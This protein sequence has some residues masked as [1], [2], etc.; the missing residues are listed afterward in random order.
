MI[1]REY[2]A[3]KRLLIVGNDADYFFS[4]RL[5]IAEAARESGFEVHIAIPYRDDDERI[6]DA[7]FSFYNVSLNRGAMNLIQD[8]AT[9]L[10]LIRLYRVVRPD[11]VHHFTIKPV[12]YGGWAAR[13]VGVGCV[14][15]SMTGLGTVFAASGAKM[16]LVRGLVVAGLRIACRGGES[17][18][19]F[20]NQH[21]RDLFVA[22]RICRP[23]STKVIQGSGVD[24]EVFH[25][26]SSQADIPL[27][28]FPS[29][30][31]W[32]KGIREFV[33]AARR[34]TNEGVVARFALVGGTDPNPTSVDPAQLEEWERE[35]IVECW[36]YRDDMPEVLR[37]C[38][39]VCM[40][41]YHEGLPK[42]LVEAAASG[43]PVIT[44]DIPGCRDIVIDGV[45]GFLVAPK[46]VSSLVDAL[47]KLLSSPELRIEFGLKG[48]EFAVQKFAKTIIN[49]QTLELYASLLR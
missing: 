41:S 15:N 31:L 26:G 13:I 30:M 49:R 46:D 39:I 11:I 1:K 38:E 33:K 5:L 10:S 43:C 24:V 40:P 32:D 16:R 35:G 29:R 17:R 47:R 23:E 22:K 3:A 19:I 48:R 28:I 6:R 36:G 14:V 42:S 21:D 34:L 27:V 44:T 18:T 7:D 12:L 8:S 20:Q 37:N 2:P 45:N 25:P 9:F 4:H